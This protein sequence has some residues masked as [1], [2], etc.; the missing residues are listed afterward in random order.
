MSSNMELDNFRLYLLNNGD[1]KTST[2]GLHT[3]NYKKLLLDLREITY[4]NVVEYL[5]SLRN[6]NLSHSYINNIICTIRVYGKYKGI[7]ELQNIK[8]LKK[9]EGIKSTMS[10]DE[11]ELFLG[12]LPATQ[13]VQAKANHDVWT[14]FFSIMAYTGMRPGEV[15]HLKVDDID[16]GREIFILRDTK[17]NKPRFVPIPPN[18]TD[19]LKE[20]IK[21]KNEYLFTST[22]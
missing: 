18:L 17:V 1:R 4:N 13:G 3:H 19:K 6:K 12:V 14:L 21:G 11:I 15:A 20:Y 22:R 9:I 10:D 2:I 8:L 7:P 5:S 16:F